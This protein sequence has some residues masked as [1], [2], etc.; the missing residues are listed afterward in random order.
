MEPARKSMKWFIDFYIFCWPAK[1]AQLPRIFCKVLFKNIPKSSQNGLPEASRSGPGGV[2]GGSQRLQNVSRGFQKRWD[3]KFYE[4]SNFSRFFEAP[5]GVQNWSKIGKK[6]MRN[7]SRF[8]MP[9]G[10][11][12]FV[13]FWSFWGGFGEVSQ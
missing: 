7:Q 12:I 13:E 1:T 5:F 9:F 10:E 8:S 3:T 4:I 11:S 6:S 2:L